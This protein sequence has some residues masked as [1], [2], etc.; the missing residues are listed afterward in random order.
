MFSLTLPKAQLAKLDEELRSSS[1]W[2]AIL[3]PRKT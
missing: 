3:S 1:R 2:S